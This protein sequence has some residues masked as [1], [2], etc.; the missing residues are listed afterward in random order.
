MGSRFKY[1]PSQE[2]DK[3]C[4]TEKRGRGEG[5][6]Y[7]CWRQCH[8]ENYNG[9]SL[10][11]WGNKTNRMHQLFGKAQIGIYWELL[12]DDSVLDIRENYPLLS[13][14]DDYLA[15]TRRIAGE[16]GFE[17]PRYS[18]SNDEKVILQDFLIK[19]KN[20]KEEAISIVSKKTDNSSSL[21]HIIKMQ[22]KYW[23][24]KKVKFITLFKED[25]NDKRVANIAFIM[26]GNTGDISKIPDKAVS[27]ALDLYKNSSDTL[28]VIADKTES[29][30]G[31]LPGSGA[32]VFMHLLKTKQ[33]VLDIDSSPIRPNKARPVEKMHA[34]T[35]KSSQHKNDEKFTFPVVN[36]IW[37]D[38][39]N[40]AYKGRQRRI[41][42]MDRDSVFLIDMNKKVVSPEEMPMEV[43]LKKIDDNEIC[44]VDDKI[45]FAMSEPTESMIREKAERSRVLKNSCISTRA[46]Y[47][48]AYRR[49]I[50]RDIA[51][52][53][54]IGLNAVRAIIVRL[55]Q[56]GF[57]DAA[58]YP[59]YK[60]KGRKKG[61]SAVNAL[62]TEEN[63]RIEKFLWEHYAVYNPPAIRD[64]YDQYC[65]TFY[66]RI[67]EV[68]DFKKSGI[69]DVLKEDYPSE[70]QFRYVFSS[71][72]DSNFDKIMRITEG[73]IEY[74]LCF[75]DVMFRNDY[76]PIGPG[77]RFFIDSTQIDYG[78]VDRNNRTR[79]LG[80]PYLTFCVDLC[81]R[82]IC[83]YYL[84]LEQ[85]SSIS[86]L[87]TLINS[88]SDK[89]A[90][91]KRF[92]FDIIEDEWPVHHMPATLTTDN[93]SAYKSLLADS[94]C[95]ELHISINSLRPRHGDDK[96]EIENLFY[97]FDCHFGKL[98]GMVDKKD[99]D[100]EKSARLTLDE[101]HKI[102][103]DFI[104]RFNRSNVIAK[105]QLPEM[106]GQDYEPTPIGLWN[107]GIRHQCG[108]IREAGS[109]D[110]MSWLLPS[111][112]ALIKKNGLS[113]R[114]LKFSCD[115]ARLKN[116]WFVKAR[117]RHEIFPK[118][119]NGF[120]VNIRFD[121]GCVDKVFYFDE[122]GDRIIFELTDHF[123][124]CYKGMAF[125]EV[126]KEQER[127]KD[128]LKKSRDY[129]RAERL[130]SKL[131]INS[132][133][134]EAEKSFRKDLKI[135]QKMDVD[136]QTKYKKDACGFYY[137]RELMYLDN[138]RINI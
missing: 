110:L 3:K 11:I 49:K 55:W 131:F 60:K 102:I 15:D 64:V 97:Q 114:K 19:R 32:T 43:F 96:A 41:I 27:F 52:L 107:W 68:K 84:S 90:Y 54:G 46:I 36:Q 47:D 134:D 133:I 65:L 123:M 45:S 29:E 94:I 25:I 40:S 4:I 18:A 88:F 79:Y 20:G 135:F 72:L 99:S 108:F 16:L 126:S 62:S 122:N 21:A 67:T 34:K 66:G 14:G 44:Q 8:E 85:E 86:L 63:L 100:Y 22:R 137:D 71:W 119:D 115:Y 70:S 13:A 118:Q 69:S 136:N 51:S 116:A 78:I 37:E 38:C 92:G 101:L 42:Y 75:R 80:R 93:G 12:F 98:P 91:C 56:S 132:V 128:M 130:C 28:D 2:H 7:I 50:E 31:L 9:T 5:S 125:D 109:E 105:E 33:V 87:M 121:P 73:D 1:T 95:N 24:E 103:I 10:R 74:S 104:I 106:V 48:S 117:N 113:F 127:I 26:Q 89:V 81:T 138:L 129:Q 53:L 120:E 112:S 35:E 23:T 61:S 124:E 59:D 58:L 39:E 57:N 76:A 30:F 17:H 6:D 111:A 77:S 83:G 82:M